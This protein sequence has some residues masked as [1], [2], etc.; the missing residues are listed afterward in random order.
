MTKRPLT[1]NEKAIIEKLL[2]KP[3]PGRDELREQLEGCL[4]QLTGDQDNYGSIYLFP[5]NKVRANVKTRVPVDGL[6]DDSDEGGIDIL[7]HVI[8]GYLNELE[9][10]KFDGT[11]LKEKIDP[12]KIKVVP[13]E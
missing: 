11:S 6:I 12:K 1:Q 7:L 5:V 13:S 9:V 8:D 10:V 4:A 3:F 2:S